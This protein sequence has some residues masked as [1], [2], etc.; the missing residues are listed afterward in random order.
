MPGGHAEP[1]LL[2]LL[3]A[4]FRLFY[5]LFHMKA[6]VTSKGQITIPA[7]LRQ[8]LALK[9]GTVLE[10]EETG[11]GFSASKRVNKARMASVIGFA[12][13]ELEGKSGMEWLDDLRGPAEFPPAAGRKR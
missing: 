10:F 3:A 13:A 4:F 12:K 5:G 7:E 8:R 1:A 2:A 11:T 6:T 9:A